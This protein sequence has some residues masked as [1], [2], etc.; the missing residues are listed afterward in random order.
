MPAFPIRKRLP[1]A[2]AAR[3]RRPETNWSE[4][5]PGIGG[6]R[7]SRG[8]HAAQPCMSIE[9]GRRR[10]RTLVCGRCSFSSFDLLYIYYLW[11]SVSFWDRVFLPKEGG[12]SC[13]REE[14]FWFRESSGQRKAS[15]VPTRHTVDELPIIPWMH[16]AL[17][18]LQKSQ[19]RAI[20]V[21]REKISRC[22]HSPHHTCVSQ[23][24]RVQKGKVH[25]APKK[26]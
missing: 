9:T 15:Q 20:E 16:E 1:A 7:A 17:A 14:P 8:L 2:A 24:C 19:N 21:E 23:P 3:A 10:C 4:R 6:A 26:K 22:R 12:K 13:S 18:P 5:R 11:L 25:A